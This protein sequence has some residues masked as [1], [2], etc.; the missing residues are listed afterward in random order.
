ME[1]GKRFRTLKGPSKACAYD[2]KRQTKIGTNNK[3]AL[4]V[5]FKFI[6]SPSLFHQLVQLEHRQQHGKHYES[7]GKPHGQDHDR[8]Y[9]C[10]RLL[11]LPV[12]FILI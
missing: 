6:I 3:S 7:D 2:E 1:R 4:N 9:K 12:E 11:H 10:K 8:F 5:F